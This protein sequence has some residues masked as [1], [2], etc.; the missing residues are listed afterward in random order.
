[1]MIYESLM[2]IVISILSYQIVVVGL[3]NTRSNIL[4]ATK[5]L[6]SDL[7]CNDTWKR[8]NVHPRAPSAHLRNAL[9]CVMNGERSRRVLWSVM[10]ELVVL[11]YESN[12][13]PP[14]R[15]TMHES[16]FLPAFLSQKVSIVRRFLKDVSIL[17]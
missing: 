4:Q 10:C 9:Q 5:K 1:M 15:R 14:R 6:G 13:R 17:F 2:H 11:W 7:A 8:V 3:L 16:I 12:E